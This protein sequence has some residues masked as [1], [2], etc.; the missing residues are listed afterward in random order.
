[1]EIVGTN[2]DWVPLADAKELEALGA[3]VVTYKGAEHAFVHDPDR[4][5]HRAKDATDAWKRAKKFLGL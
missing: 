4:P 5:A 2:D 1:M 3:T